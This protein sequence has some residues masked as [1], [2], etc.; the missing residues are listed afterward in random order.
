MNLIQRV[1]DILLKPKQTWPVIA[2][3]SADTASIYTGYVVILAA[4]PAIA[5]FI[6]LL[7]L[8][9]IERHE[10]AGEIPARWRLG[11]NLLR[12]AQG[13]FWPDEVQTQRV[14]KLRTAFHRGHG[15][16]LFGIRRFTRI[17][18]RV[19]SRQIQA[20][21]HRQHGKRSPFS[22]DQPDARSTSGRGLCKNAA[23]RHCSV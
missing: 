14:Q 6:G 21:A 3:E 13:F 11:Q 16:F 1:Q 7:V 5:G 10:K 19:S 23:I 8:V 9:C 2:Q 18:Q 4:I 20:I 17:T 22:S 15:H 12:G